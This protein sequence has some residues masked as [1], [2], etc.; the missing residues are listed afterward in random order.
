VQQRRTIASRT[1]LQQIGLA[2]GGRA[3]VRLATRLGMPT[4]RMTLLRRVRALELPA[5][6]A[7]TVVGIDDWAWRKGR[8]YGTIV[9]DLERHCPIALLPTR[10]VEPV[11]QWLRTH[12][13][14]AII[15]R[16]RAEAYAEAATRGAP[17]AQQVA[18]RWHLLR[19]LGDT[20]AQVFERYARFLHPQTPSSLP[21][22]PPTQRTPDG[23][24][25]I[26]PPTPSP[27]AADLVVKRRAHRVARYVST[28]TWI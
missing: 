2:L 11:A 7:P 12:P 16:D 24:I 9:V 15:A 13:D 23:A 1:A 27:H 17:A 3:G 22:A 6:P 25:V 14:I 10:E 28:P 18:D 20:V 26:P 5:Y 21:T 19:N 8:T 4:S